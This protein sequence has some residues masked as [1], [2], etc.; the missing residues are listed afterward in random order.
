MEQDQ[1]TPGLIWGCV[2]IDFVAAHTVPIIYFRSAEGSRLLSIQD[3][4]CLAWGDLGLTC[5]RVCLFLCL[6]DSNLVVRRGKPEHVVAELIKQL[7]S[8]STVAFQKE[9]VLNN[10]TVISDDINDHSF[11]KL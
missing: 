11:I 9:V 3:A 5:V 10:H 2:Y 4:A 7:G 1:D 6:C 8:V